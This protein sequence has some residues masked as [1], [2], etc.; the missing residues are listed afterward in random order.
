MMTEYP[1]T[2]GDLIAFVF[3]LVCAAVWFVVESVKRGRAY[4]AAPVLMFDVVYP[5][6]LRKSVEAK[7]AEDAARIVADDAN[8]KHDVVLFSPTGRLAGVV[9]PLGRGVNHPTWF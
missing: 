7:T 2:H 6:G 3:L 1:A 5:N 4:R 9:R 8:L